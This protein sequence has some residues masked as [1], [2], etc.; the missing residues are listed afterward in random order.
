MNGTSWADEATDQV[1]NFPQVIS[2]ENGIKTVVEY[3]INEDGKKVKITKRIR[4]QV[5]KE[6][7]LRSVAERKKWAKFGQEA[8]NP[9]GPNIST[10]N[11]G[12][13]VFLK[14]SQWGTGSKAEEEE[15]D[16]LNPKNDPSKSKTIT[17]RLCKGRHFTSKCP[18]KSTLESLEDISLSAKSPDDAA[19]SP[20]VSSAS[21]VGGSKNSNYV[22]PHLRNGNKSQTTDSPRDK[23]DDLP[24]IRITNLSEDTKETDVQALCKPFGSVSRVF[25]AKDWQTG[26]CKGYSFVS[27]YEKSSAQKALDKLNGY[28]FD[29]LIL[30]VEWSNSSN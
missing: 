24:T 8:G 23:R 2:D 22:P 6:R 27:Y 16:P 1:L 18:Y 11:V 10:T 26:Q 5:V 12:E 28:G 13:Q 14:L 20:K 15:D 30:K 4:T 3:R 17:C 25:L 29:N 19:A 9:P 7:V 21:S